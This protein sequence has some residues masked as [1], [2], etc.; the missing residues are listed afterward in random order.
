MTDKTERE[1]WLVWNG[2]G[3]S[4]PRARHYS[5]ANAQAEAMRLAGLH[6]GTVFYALKAVNA[7]V[8]EIDVKPIFLDGTGSDGGDQC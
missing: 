8:A 7:Y 4:L 3:N 5:I 1:F 2:G 6:P